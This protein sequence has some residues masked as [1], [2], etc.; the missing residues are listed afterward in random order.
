MP[1]A[2]QQNAYSGRM[3]NGGIGEYD[4][5]YIGDLQWVRLS[6]RLVSCAYLS[7]MILYCDLFCSLIFFCSGRLM[8]IYGKSQLMSGSRSTTRT[9][10]FQNT[11]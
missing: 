3:L 9:S 8:K 11:K 7:E 4:A 1:A 5:L 10:R 6:C 2:N